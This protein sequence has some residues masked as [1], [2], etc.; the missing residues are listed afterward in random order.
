[1]GLLDTVAISQKMVVE[2]SVVE[3]P[4]SDLSGNYDISYYLLYSGIS[5]AI[6][7]FAGAMS[8]LTVGL[9]SMDNL[10]LEMKI[11]SRD[12]SE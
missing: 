2:S 9:L 11:Q 12:L 6:V 1:V 4:P 3:P 5:L 7:I 10:V 8:G